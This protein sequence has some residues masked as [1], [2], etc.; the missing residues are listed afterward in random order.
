M[1]FSGDALTAL[2]FYRS[3]FGGELEVHT[4]GEIGLQGDHPDWIAHGILAGPIDLFAADEAN[5]AAHP[6]PSGLLFS[7]L[8]YA[9]PDTLRRWFDGLADG[10]VVIDPLSE[11]DWGA[12]DGQVR[13]RFG[14]T[15][16][17]GW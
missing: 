14:I 3:V 8:G 2:T 15:W 9:D 12:S 5:A 1:H 11:R 10:G 6:D 7:L 13:D 17:L 16:L 4:H